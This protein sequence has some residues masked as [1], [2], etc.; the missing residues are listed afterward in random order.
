MTTIDLLSRV[1]ESNNIS[2]GRAEMI[3][4]IIVEKIS[5]RLRKEG[6]AAIDNFGV[7]KILSKNITTPGFGE[8][9]SVKRNYI[10]FTPDKLFVDIINS[11]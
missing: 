8:Q 1:S 10:L 9:E 4:S 2:T 3:L 6:E 5:D 11:K 7:F